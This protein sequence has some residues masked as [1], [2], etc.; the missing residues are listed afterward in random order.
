MCCWC[1]DAK[2]WLCLPSS[3][4]VLDPHEVVTKAYSGRKQSLDLALDEAALLAK[5]CCQEHPVA[6]SRRAANE[7]LLILHPTELHGAR[8]CLWLC[9]QGGA[10]LFSFEFCLNVCM[11]AS[12]QLVP[13]DLAMMITRVPQLQKNTDYF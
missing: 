10:Q 8:P 7:L 5:Q 4:P 3:P 13:G 1:H 6:A 12:R 9:G 11:S 2:L